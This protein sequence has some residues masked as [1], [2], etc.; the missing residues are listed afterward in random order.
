MHVTAKATVSTPRI[1]QGDNMLLV[2]YTC[3]QCE[4]NYTTFNPTSKKMKITLQRKANAKIG[5][6]KKISTKQNS[7][8]HHAVIYQGFIFG[9]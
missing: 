8:T 6:T 7:Q 5:R 4:Y 2:Q 1:M 9:D 3:A